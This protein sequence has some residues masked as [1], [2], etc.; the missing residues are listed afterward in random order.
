MGSQPLLTAG[1]A[2]NPARIC[3]FERKAELE[4]STEFYLL[5]R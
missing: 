1:G 3:C 4:R 5:L 2:Q